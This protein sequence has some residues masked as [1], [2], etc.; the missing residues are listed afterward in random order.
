MM[1]LHK[2]CAK[3]HFASNDATP[4]FRKDYIE[5]GSSGMQRTGWGRRGGWGR[6]AGGSYPGQPWQG[7]PQQQPVGRWWHVDE[8]PGAA[9]GPECA[10]QLLWQ[11]LGSEPAQWPAT[12]THSAVRMWWQLSQVTHFK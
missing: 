11:L 6:G 5:L 9:P 2:A 12:Y 1:W 8:M 10:P 7:G 4:A 3:R